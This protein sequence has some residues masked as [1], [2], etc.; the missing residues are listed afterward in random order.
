M[1][2]FLVFGHQKKLAWLLLSFGQLIWVILFRLWTFA[3]CPCH[4]ILLVWVSLIQ[5]KKLFLPHSCI[6]S[7]YIAFCGSHVSLNWFKSPC[8]R[9]KVIGFVFAVF[10]YFFVRRYQI[11]DK[12][13]LSWLTFPLLERHLRSLLLC[14]ALRAH[15]IRLWGSVCLGRPHLTVWLLVTGQSLTQNRRAANKT[16]IWLDWDA[17][18]GL[19]RKR[20]LNTTDCQR[21][22][23]ICWACRLKL[24]KLLVTADFL[25]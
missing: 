4:R 18:G 23:R 20:L 3:T 11:L 17:L 8:L 1:A 2:N 21:C 14:G 13:W 6:I 10:G 12:F 24:L 16:R 5:F 25:V 9:E 7:F 19:L 15:L 22:F